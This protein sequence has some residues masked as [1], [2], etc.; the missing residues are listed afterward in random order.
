MEVKRLVTVTGACFT[1]SLLSSR[2]SYDQDRKYEFRLEDMAARRGTRGLTV[3][4]TRVAIVNA[5]DFQSR[6]HVLPWNAVRRAFDTG[7]LNFD[8]WAK[9]Q[10]TELKIRDA[11]APGAREPAS[12]EIVR[13]YLVA[14]LY[15][16]GYRYRLYDNPVQT[17]VD[18]E[19]EEDLDY[20]GARREDLRRVAWRM[21]QDGLL[22]PSGSSGVANPTEKLLKLFESGNWEAA[23]APETVAPIAAQDRRFEEMAL[24]EARKSKPEDDRVHPKVGVVVVKDGRVLGAAYRGEMTGNHAEFIALEKKLAD[25]QIAGATVYTTLEPCTSRKHP[26]VPCAYRLRERKVARVVIGMLDPNP[27]IRGAGQLALRE[28]NIATDLFPRD[29]M[30]Q[31]EEMNREFIRMYRPAQSV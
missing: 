6:E 9:D 13:E 5:H 10:W 2:G 12:D 19:S 31:V 30:A 29:L 1:A 8:S 18:L 27:V 24:E 16:L 21:E 17:C 4:F 20:L 15:W 28:A 23:L 25:Q 22:Q 14:K 3:V 26:K 7:E 11:D